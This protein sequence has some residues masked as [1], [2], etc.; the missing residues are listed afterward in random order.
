MQQTEAPN[1][2]GAQIY[3]EL[4]LQQYRLQRSIVSH[5]EL[6]TRKATWG[7]MGGEGERGGQGAYH[8]TYSTI[9]RVLY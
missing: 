4:Y 3:L 5:K 7:G 2:Q 6:G 9:L 1:E 8:S